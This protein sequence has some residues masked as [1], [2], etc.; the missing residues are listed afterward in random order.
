[1][2][3]DLRISDGDLV[4]GSDG[5]FDK[6]EGTEKLIQDVLKLLLTP[7]GGNIF[8]PFYGSLL[9]RSLIGQPFDFELISTVSSSQIQSSLETLQKLQQGQSLEQSVTP[10]EQI[11]AIKNVTI[12][13]NRT[14][15]RFFSVFIDVITRAMSVTQ[16]EFTINNTQGL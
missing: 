4:I 12:Q 14:D 13:R 1:M 15:P 5:D 6:V 2:S 9:S 3:F 8:Y 16:I 10:F 7:L 11:A